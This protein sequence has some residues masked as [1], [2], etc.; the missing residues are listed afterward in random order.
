MDIYQHFRLEEHEQID[1]LLDK[2]RQAETQYAPVLTYFLDPRGQYMLEVIAGSFNDL[3]VSFDGDVMRRGV[4][5]LLRQAIM[6]RRGMTL[7]W[8]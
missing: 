5:R 1:Y 8:L 6:N 7:N 2:V 3:H 4:G